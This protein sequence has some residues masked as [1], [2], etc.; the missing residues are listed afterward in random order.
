MANKRPIEIFMPPNVLK[1]KMGNGKLDLSAVKRAEQAIDNLKS[2]FTGWVIHDVSRLVEA[3]QAYVK[4]SNGETLADLYRAAHDL[5]GQAATFDFPLI[6]RVASSLCMLTD[7]TSYGLPLPLNLI[8][9]HIVAIKVI[10]R[11][12]LKDPSDRTATE[13]ASELEQ[14][15]AGFLEKHAAA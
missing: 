2:E 9:A 14:Q 12:N 5:K 10:V 11:D 1:A 3:G 13:L 15:V 4:Q 7:D 8:E 6:S